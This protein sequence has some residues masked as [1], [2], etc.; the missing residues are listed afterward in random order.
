MTVCAWCSVMDQPPIQG[1]VQPC[2]QHTWD[3]LWTTVLTVDETDDSTHDRTVST[4]V[5]RTLYRFVVRLPSKGKW[6]QSMS[7]KPPTGYQIHLIPS[8]RDQ[9]FQAC[10]I[11]TQG[12]EQS[13]ALTIFIPQ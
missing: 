11:E 10:S 12:T 6:T 4:S 13:E 1:E 9:Y 7:A 8:L 3:R 5:R 2:T